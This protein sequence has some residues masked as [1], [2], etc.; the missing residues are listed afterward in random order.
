VKR[1][2]HD[3]FSHYRGPLMKKVYLDHSATTP[4]REEVGE[5]M[6]PYFSDIFGNPSSLH[7]SGQGAR[8]AIEACRKKTA[9]ILNVNAGEIIFTSGGTESDNL[10][11]KG[12]AHAARNKGKHIITSSIEH[13]A[14]LNCCRHLEA[15][16]YEVTY[17]P[18]DEQAVV[19]PESV[20]SAI[21]S[22]TVLISVMLANNEV[23]SIQPVAELGK[24][25]LKKNIVLHTDAV[26]AAGKIPLRPDELNVDLLSIS[27]HKIYGP[28]GVGL[29][30]IRKGTPIEPMIHG[31]RHEMGFRPGTE[32]VA[33]IVGL[34]KALELAEQE[35]EE[36]CRKT[37]HLRQM[38][39]NGIAETI[40]DIRINEHPERQLPNILNVSF[41]SVDG[42]SLLLVLDTK[43][44]WVST[45][46]AC[47]SGSGEASHVLRAMHVPENMAG[48][49]IR[50]SLGRQNTETEICRVLG[51]LPRIVSGLRQARINVGSGPGNMNKGSDRPQEKVTP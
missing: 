8:R 19:D 3:G 25:T 34:A 40:A 29:L 6:G 38:L 9:A 41:G 51:M 32:N 16:G 5:T 36:F 27:A 24:L 2:N 44:I 39:K 46:A 48:G 14:V 45:G 50:F 21:R 31:G 26:Q 22:D 18:V 42:E 47:S 12:A 7:S 23:G 15:E 20:I 49:S 37:S 30:Y 35:R 17:L 13:S 43:G 11:I 28:K 10:A 33:G 1:L 4:V